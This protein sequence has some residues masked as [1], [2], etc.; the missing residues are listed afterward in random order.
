MTDETPFEPDRTLYERWRSLPSAPAAAP[1]DAMTLAAYLDGR[2]DE[3]GSAAIEAALAA[4]PKLLD[5]LLDLRRPMAAE[6]APGGIVARAQALV[7]ALPAKVV[8]F[9]PR[10]TNGMSALMAWGAMAASLVLV[11]LVGFDLGVRTEQSLSAPGTASESPTDLFYQSG[12]L[13]DG[14][15]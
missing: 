2:L 15:G 11:S 4:D 6:P 1:P 12:T 7:D 14:I 13:D 5:L 8:P 3:S 9:R 10:R